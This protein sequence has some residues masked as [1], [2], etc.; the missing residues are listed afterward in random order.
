MINVFIRP[1]LCWQYPGK[2]NTRKKTNK[3]IL[4]TLTTHTLHSVN[5]IVSRKPC[6]ISGNGSYAEL[7]CCA[8][9]FCL[10]QNCTKRRLIV[11]IF[12][13]IF[14]WMFF[15]NIAF[16]YHPQGTL[17]KFNMIFYLNTL[18]LIFCLIKWVK[19]NSRYVKM[20]DYHRNDRRKVF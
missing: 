4:H 18:K 13:C 14:L 15:R 12:L 6:V 20:H 3:I 8:A 10:Y 1:A 2:K 16:Y 17:F 5:Y 7:Y 11:H 19:F 9:N